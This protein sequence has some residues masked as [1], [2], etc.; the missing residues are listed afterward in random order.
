MAQAARP[1][2]HIGGASTMSSTFSAPRSAD[3]LVAKLGFWS[4]VGAAAFSI[5]FTVGAIVGVLFF[6]QAAWTG[7]ITAFAAKYNPTSMELGVV[8]SILLAP[9]FLGLA[10]AVH[11]GARAEKKPVTL[12]G[13][14]FATIYVATVGINYFLQ[15]TVI[16]QNLIAG[17]NDAMGL[18][19][20][21]NT[22]SV[23]WTLEF[24]GYFWQGAAALCLAAYF[25]APGLG[26]W[27]R[28]MLIAVFASG[29]LGVVAAVRGTTFSDPLFIAG[30]AVWALCFP[31]AMI[32]GAVYFRRLR[33]AS[34]AN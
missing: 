25:I 13:L 16:R 14:L 30:G 2:R 5:A 22:Q 32:L 4:A 20:M 34:N 15:L 31:A 3:A 28:W 21:S 23:F 6:P 7:D 8:P 27:T 19:A 11:S 29:A 10:V 1:R 18:F 26:R 33:L 9:A 17:T 24:L 12:L